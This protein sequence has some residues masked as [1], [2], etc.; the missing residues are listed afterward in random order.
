MKKFFRD[1]GVPIALFA[2]KILTT[3]RTA[4]DTY[5]VSGDLLNVLLIDLAFLALWM[6]LAYGGDNQYAKRARPFAT[7]G[8]WSMYIMMLMIGWE[9]HHGMVAVAVRIAGGIGLLLDTWDYIMATVAPAWKRY[10]AAQALPPDVGAYGRKLM[11]TRL[12]GAVREGVGKLDPHMKALALDYLRD[13]MPGVV[14]GSVSGVMEI[15]QTTS[16]NRVEFRSS[17]VKLWNEAV[18]PH[19]SNGQ[20]FSRETIESAANCKRSLAID[21]INYGKSQGYVQMKGRGEYV[22]FLPVTNV[23]AAQ[24]ID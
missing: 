18:I 4:F 22:F 9:A 12:K 19:L 1:Y 23:R 24:L 8:A 7:L 14:R 10:Q 17:V 5:A 16:E 13:E 3:I 15:P 6:L 21:L 2:I 11:Q 20:P